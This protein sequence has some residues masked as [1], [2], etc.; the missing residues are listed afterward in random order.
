MKY[1]PPD[2]KQLY[3]EIILSEGFTQSETLTKNGL[4]TSFKNHLMTDNYNGEN[5][6]MNG[7][8]V[9]VI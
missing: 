6:L 2:M 5:H 1:N 4:Q 3:S 8:K 9:L 7:Y